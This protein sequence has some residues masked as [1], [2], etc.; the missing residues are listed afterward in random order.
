MPSSQ[1]LSGRTRPQTQPVGFQSLPI[2]YLA[3]TNPE[4]L[5]SLH[6]AQ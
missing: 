5:S 4:V 3:L 2:D 6:E 1:L